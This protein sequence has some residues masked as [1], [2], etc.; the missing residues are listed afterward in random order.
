MAVLVF[1]W[2]KSLGEVRDL[3]PD[4]QGERDARCLGFCTIWFQVLCSIIFIV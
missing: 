3:S 1:K 2:A 4:A